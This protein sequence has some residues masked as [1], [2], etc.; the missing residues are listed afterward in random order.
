MNNKIVS[1]NKKLFQVN[2]DEYNKV[3][4]NEYNNLNI[5][6]QLGFH[7]RQISL[8]KELSKMFKTYY[9]N[10]SKKIN[11]RMNDVSHGGFIPIHCS[12]YYDNIYINQNPTHSDHI[13]YNI[14]KHLKN[15]NIFY[16]LSPTNKKDLYE[17]NFDNPQSSIF[18][19][20]NYL[21]DLNNQFIK[22]ELSNFSTKWTPQPTL[23]V[24]VSQNINETFVNHFKYYIQNN[25]LNYDNLIHLCIMVKNAGPQFEDTLKKN[26]KNIDRWTILDTGS[27]DQTIELV[28][29]TLVGIKQGELYEEPFINFRDS[30]NKC[31]DLAG[32]DCKF[33]MMLDDTYVIDGNLREFLNIVRGDQ[34]SDSFTLFIKSDDT[35]YGSNRIIK[36]DSGLRYIYKIHEVITDKDNKNVVIP[37]QTAKIID[38]RFDYM[39]ERTKNRKQLDLKLLYEEVED[40]PNNPRTYYYLAQTYNQLEDYQKAFYY[41]M[42][43]CE[44]VNSGFLQERVDAAFEAARIA[45]FKLNRPWEECLQLYERAFKIDETRPESLYFIGIHYYMEGNIIDAYKYL[46]RGFEIGYPYHCQYSLKPT[47]SFH[48]LPKFLTRVCYQYCIED[49]KLGQASSE[50]FLINNTKDAEDY[51]EML[52]WYKIYQKLNSYD[53]TRIPRSSNL[54]NKPLFVFV[55]DGGF[56][57][58]SGSSIIKEGVGGSETY[59]IE[60]A[61]YIQEEGTF[62]VVVFC[63]CEDEEDFEGVQYKHLNDYSSFIFQYKIH[64]CVIS[65]FSEYLPLSYKGFIDNIYFILHDLTPSGNVIPINSKLKRIFC[66]TEWHVTYFTNIFPQLKH[67]TD[68]FYYGIDMQKFEKNDSQKIPNKFIYSSFPNRGLLPLLK[69]WPRIWNKENTSSLHIYS[70]IEGKWVNS[71]EPE[72]MNEIRKILLEYSEDN[73]GNNYKYNIFYHG[74]VD[75]KTLSESWKTAD[76][77][78]YPCTFAETFCLTAL[79][80][81]IT[82]TF[83]ITNGLAALENTVGDRGVIIKGNPNNDEWQEQALQQIFYYMDK[84]NVK[85]KNELINKNYDWSSQLS[86]KNRANNLLKEYIQYD[87]KKN[88]NIKNLI[89]LTV[90]HNKEY[91]KL[92]EI[93]L[94]SLYLFGNVNYQTTHLLIYTSNEFKK[95]IEKISLTKNFT[96]H[97]VIND[98]KNTKLDSCKARLD[99]FKFYIVKYYENILYLDTDIIINNDINCLFDLCQEDILYCS[100]ENQFK[101]DDSNCGNNWGLRLFTKEE[102]QNIKDKRGINSGT[103]LFKNKPNVRKVFNDILCDKRNVEEIYDQELINYHFIKNNLVDKDKLEKYIKF[104]C[105]DS[106][107]GDL[108]YNKSILHFYVKGIEEKMKLMTTFLNKKI[109]QLIDQT[110]FSVKKQ[111]TENLFPIVQQSNESLEGCF[112]S[113]HLTN[114]ISDFRI[115]NAMNICHLLLTHN[116]I[117]N[118]LEIGFNAGFSSFLMLSI[119]PGIQLTCVDIC[120]HK[121][122]MPCYEWLSKKFPN[123]VSIIKGNSEEMLPQL[124]KENSIYDMIHIDGGHS[125]KTFFHDVQNSIKLSHKNTFIVIDDYDFHYINVVWN[126][127]VDYHKMIR[128]EPYKETKTQIIHKLQ[129]K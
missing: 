20:L 1:I 55:A 37:I 7:E 128:I 83:V 52:S 112:F 32:A 6:D 117:K 122:T 114:V 54:S 72:Q 43:R 119:H 66:L 94:H 29:N 78:F 21:N 41:F 95:M 30:R 46:K 19:S 67:L 80:A 91:I 34:Y 86:W 124:V 116:N 90:F 126:L 76:F 108:Y 9:S 22:Y 50:F 40:D 97:F 71:V 16:N 24:Y 18:I 42:K 89:F 59:I 51:E 14:L 110:I 70:D 73:L 84:E 125:T 100:Y 68:P 35:E 107:N 105:F 4:H 38:K 17:I 77:W 57:K 87:E 61:R 48:F 31:L 98:S 129:N 64:T 74:W 63:N 60:M 109:E 44:F 2:N 25:K 120:E 62:Q 65:R 93:F 113:E 123:R 45:N 47:L 26:M 15:K 104:I 69:M 79:E 11:V 58:W 115:E 111:I 118:I 121:Y 10:P 12:Y 106:K 23:Y 96:I 39:E 27:T 81:A 127:F 36:S 8:L 101:I 28:H 92:F 5:L 102:I 103:L 56:K 3:I 75:K 53:L 33:I 99:L 13:Q 49:F 88:Q 85:E 82:K